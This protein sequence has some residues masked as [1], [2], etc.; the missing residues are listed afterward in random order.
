MNS[1]TASPPKSDG[2][3]HAVSLGTPSAS[4]LVASTVRR[5]HSRS[6]AF[7]ERR[8]RVDDVLAVVEH[9]QRRLVA[10]SHALSE[11]TAD[12]TARSGSRSAVATCCGTSAASLIGARSVHPMFVKSGTRDRRGFS[13]ESRLS[14]AARA[15]EREQPRAGEDARNLLQFGCPPDEPCEVHGQREAVT[16]GMVETAGVKTVV[17][18]RVP[19]GGWARC[20]RYVLGS[21]SG[22]KPVD[23][24]HGCLGGRLPPH[25]QYGDLS[26]WCRRREGSRSDPVSSAF[27]RGISTRS[28]ETVGRDEGEFERRKTEAARGHQRRRREAEAVEKGTESW[29]EECPRRLADPGCTPAVQRPGR[30]RAP[31]RCWLP[32]F[33]E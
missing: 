12:A 26:H 16:G 15:R 14:A 21:T 20:Q 24:F 22:N 11:S 29:G 13:R 9:E 32:R 10:E 30:R 17:L 25:Q 7:D 23:Q 4:R 27:P 3:S 28:L 2:T 1:C 33:R 19:R 6:R 31:A 18:M 8:A 5:G